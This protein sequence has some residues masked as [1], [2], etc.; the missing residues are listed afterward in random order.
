MVGAQTALLHSPESMPLVHHSQ[1]PVERLWFDV[2]RVSTGLSAE[3]N[4]FMDPLSL[5]ISDGKHEAGRPMVQRPEG[6]G[7][8]CLV[9]PDEETLPPASKKDRKSVV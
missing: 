2:G 8:V 6:L 1:W 4:V 5:P 3:A 7:C 9:S